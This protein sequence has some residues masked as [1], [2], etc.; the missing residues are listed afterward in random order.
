MLA[1]GL[2]TYLPLIKKL[3]DDGKITEGRLDDA[4]KRIL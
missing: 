1:G 4:V 3:V 2:D